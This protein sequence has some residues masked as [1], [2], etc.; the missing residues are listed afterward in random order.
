MLLK[1]KEEQIVLLNDSVDAN[2]S[3]ARK[4]RHA[5]VCRNL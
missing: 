4:K 3:G 5:C 1:F 2:L